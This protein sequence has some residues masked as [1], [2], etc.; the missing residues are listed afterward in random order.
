MDEVIK[1]TKPGWRTVLLREEVVKAI[2]KAKSERESASR[3]RIALGAFIEELVWQVI[4][5]QETLRKYGPFIEKIAI[6]SNE[7]VLRD[8]RIG[9]IVECIVKE[10]ELYCL[11]CQSLNCVHIGYSW[12][13]PEVYK[14]MNLKGK[15]MPK[16]E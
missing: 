3:R 6:D 12:A 15:K 7:I 2:E 9:R 14:I 8:N 16:I 4:E 10:G 13:I 5:G 1:L 11:H